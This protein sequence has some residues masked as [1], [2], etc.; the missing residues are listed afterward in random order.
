M[1]TLKEI[2]YKGRDNPNTIL[3]KQNLNDG[4]GSL[5]IDFTSVTRYTL[6][7]AGV[8]IDTDITAGAI[9][10]DALGQIILNIND[11][12]IAEGEYYGRLVTYDATHTDGQ[13]IIHED[14]TS[15]SDR[16]L[17]SFRDA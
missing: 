8:T 12:A 3:I 15:I 11:V 10:G 17:L 1:A 13:V 16:L 6:F 4:N 14:Q 2:V 5:A 9:T 7:V